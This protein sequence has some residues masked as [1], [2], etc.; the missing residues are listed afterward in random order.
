[1]LSSVDVDV[2]GAGS[3][4]VQKDS[5]ESIDKRMIQVLAQVCAI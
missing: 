4:E 5:V 2:C 3:T 1:M